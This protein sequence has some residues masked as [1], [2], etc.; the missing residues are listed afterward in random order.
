MAKFLDNIKSG[1][2]KAVA[3]AS[4]TTKAMME[5]NKINAVIDNL[6]KDKKELVELLGQKTYDVFKLNSRIENDNIVSFITEIDKR[7]EQIEAQKQELNRVDEEL[8]MV[9]KGGSTGIVADGVACEC[10]GINAEDAKFCVKCGSSLS[11][12]GVQ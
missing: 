2:G 12:L 4:A 6:E 1:A 11:G 3:T 9:T 5:K 10:G 7:I 8:A